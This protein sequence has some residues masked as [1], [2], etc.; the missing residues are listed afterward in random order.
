MLRERSRIEDL[1]FF[2]FFFYSVPKRMQKYSDNWA[3]EK[4]SVDK[5]KCI[6]L[7][8]YVFAESRCYW[9]L[10]CWRFVCGE[11]PRRETQQK[12]LLQLPGWR[13]TW[14]NRLPCLKMA[15]VKGPLG[16]LRGAPVTSVLEPSASGSALLKE[17]RAKTPPWLVKCLN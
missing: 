8:G 2:F 15:V 13:L 12:L 1:F 3:I 16:R 6:S 10:H 5:L 11:S 4:S 7:C 9:T 14:M 17:I